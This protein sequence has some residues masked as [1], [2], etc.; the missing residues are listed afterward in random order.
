[1]QKIPLQLVA[2]GMVLGRDVFRKDSVGGIPICG[3]DT[4]LTA[5]LV[6]R[7]N[8]MDIK[9]IYVKGH[10]VML[11]GERSLDQALEE[12]DRRFEKVISDPQMAR[13]RDIYADYLQRVMGDDSGR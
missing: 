8:Y 4:V 6:K 7:L 1:M 5:E 2:E 13:I 9:S 11:D 3:K 12:L 10:P